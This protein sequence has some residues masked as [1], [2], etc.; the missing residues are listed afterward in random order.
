MGEGVPRRRAPVQVLLHG[1]VRPSVLGIFLAGAAGAVASGALVA[2]DL[3]REVIRFAILG[4]SVVAMRWRIEVLERRE[5]TGR[6]AVPGPVSLDPSKVPRPGAGSQRRLWIASLGLVG[7]AVGTGMALVG[8]GV[9]VAVEGAALRWPWLRWAVALGGLGVGAWLVGA[10]LVGLATL[11]GAREALRRTAAGAAP[12]Q[13]ADV[14]A[15]GDGEVALQ[16][17]S[18]G[19]HAI[20]RMAFPHQL[21]LVAGEQVVVDGELRPGAWVAVSTSEGA[22]WGRVA[23]P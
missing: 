5:V 2:D 16:Q 1:L 6:R 11:R 21:P 9:V 13:L 15:A 20:L 19:A 14:H 3:L 4:A 10:A 7:G 23:S 8:A 18:A 17:A 12:R 22:S